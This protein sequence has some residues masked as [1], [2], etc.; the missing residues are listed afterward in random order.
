MILI[1]VTLLVLSSGAFCE[2]P[3]DFVLCASYSAGS[4]AHPA[5]D[6]VPEAA[7]TEKFIKCKEYCYTVWLE[8]SNDNT[9]EVLGQGCWQASGKPPECE[10]S[11]C[12]YDK[13][14]HKSL[15]STKFCCCNKDKCNLNYTDN[16]VPTEAPPTEITPKD[17]SLSPLTYLC[18]GFTF[19][20]LTVV[21]VIL[22]YIFWKMKETNKS[23]VENCQ[24]PLP[25]PT[26]YSLDNLRIMNLIGQGKYGTVYRGTIDDTLDVAVKVFPAH[27][28]NYFLNEHEMFKICG[29]NAGVLKCFGGG[30]YAMEYV[31]LLS[32]E[33]ESLQDYLKRNTIDLATLGKMSLSVAKGLAHLHLDVGKPC[34]AHRDVNS[35][36]ILVRG[37]LSCCISDL[38]LAV[39]PKRTENKALSEAGTLRYMAPEV[40]EGAVNLRDCESALKQIDV[41]ALGLVL[42]ELGCRCTDMQNAEPHPYLPPFAKEA[43][44]HP[45]LEQMQALVSRKK[46]RPLWPVSWK[47][48]ASARLLCDTAEDCWDQDAEARLTALCIAERL[49]EL[50]TLKGRCLLPHHPPASPTPLINNNHLHGNQFDASI[51]TIETL[52]SPS[53]EN[54][55][56]SNRLVDCVTPLQPYQGRNPCL[57]RN[58]LSSSS[59]S[60]LIDKSSKHCTGSESQNLIPNE[61]LDFQINHRATPIPYLQNAVYGMPKRQNDAYKTPT[62]SRF[63]WHGLRNFLNMKMGSGHSGGRKDTQVKLDGKVVN[64]SGVTTSLLGYADE[65]ARPSSL[66]LRPI[67]CSTA[68]TNCG[69]SQL[70]KREN[71]LS[72]QRSLDHFNEVFSS[73]GDLS[74]LKDPSQRVK[75]PGDVPPSVR[76]TRGKAAADS[77]RFSLYDDRMM[78]QAQWGSAP[79]LESQKPPDAAQ[80]SEGQ[81]KDSVSSF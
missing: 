76:R 45:T 18:L 61:F 77:A 6:I 70:L 9:F 60:L 19:L 51:N 57:E 7:P 28:R 67:E 29:D 17:E 80:T 69:V 5:D 4:I 62:K 68:N 33:Q 73:T 66:R 75:T 52:L 72:R 74:R 41:Y 32:L 36:N 3:D 30:E 53:E 38:G 58:L 25:P 22:S 46:A 59:D 24:Q 10:R 8:D 37:D 21:I 64:G 42:W 81:D 65:A 1:A 47:D 12:T 11:L 44:D 55:K 27:H 15:N 78:G 54:C 31:L 13:E 35:R 23:D 34:I 71:N 63:K 14:P 79:D 40:L 26:E 49:I 48:T 16:Y 50:P 20:A 39:V 56:N 43:G 2:E